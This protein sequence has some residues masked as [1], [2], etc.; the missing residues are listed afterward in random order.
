MSLGVNQNRGLAFEVRRTVFASACLLLILI[1]SEVSILVALQIL[2]LL[3]AQIFT[4]DFATRL[5]YSAVFAQRPN[6]ETLEFFKELSVR[7]YIIDLEKANNGLWD[8]N[9]ATVFANKSFVLIDID[10]FEL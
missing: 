5:R 10:K 2:L 9:S 3:V 8:A 1:F 4:G 6:S 7:W